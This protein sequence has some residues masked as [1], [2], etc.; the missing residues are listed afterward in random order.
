MSMTAVGI[1]S[2]RSFVQIGFMHAIDL[3]NNTT[4]SLPFT[5]LLLLLFTRPSDYSNKCHTNAS[6]QKTL[7]CIIL[8]A[9]K[10]GWFY[11]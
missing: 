8:A 2:H 1:Y 7:P 11:L 3:V 5:L 9:V 4:W 10:D 6:L